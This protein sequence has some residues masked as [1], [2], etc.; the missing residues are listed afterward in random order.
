VPSGCQGGERRQFAQSA[1]TRLGDAQQALS[2][3]EDPSFTWSRGPCTS[4]ATPHPRERKLLSVAWRGRF[5]IA[6][7]QT[8]VSRRN[9]HRGRNERT[10]RGS[11]RV[12]ASLR[13]RSCVTRQK[14]KEVM[15]FVPARKRE[16]RLMSVR[17]GSLQKSAGRILIPNKLARSAPKRA[18][19]R[20]NG[21]LVEGLGGE[22]DVKA[23]TILSPRR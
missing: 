9:R 13:G 19:V 21:G 17:R 10:G 2:P 14:R 23:S 11:P 12:T 18:A 4:F 3:F 16:L 7:G 20:V 15:A 8:C 6:V 22:V 1:S 5:G